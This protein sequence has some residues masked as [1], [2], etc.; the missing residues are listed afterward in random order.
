MLFGSIA[1]T[2]H[3]MHADNAV[4]GGSHFM[5]DVGDKTAFGKTGGQ[6][7]ITGRLQLAGALLY[8]VFQ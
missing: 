2:Q 3:V 5:T 8:L 7:F 1:F 4:Q 6:R